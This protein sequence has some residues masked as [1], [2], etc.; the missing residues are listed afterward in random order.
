M[1]GSPGTTH[2]TT[3]GPLYCSAALYYFSTNGDLMWNVT[4]SLAVTTLWLTE[5]MIWQ[6][7]SPMLCQKQL[8][9]SNGGIPE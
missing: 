9:N 8:P 5:A 4:E 1:A 3:L 7:E 6:Y 2:Y